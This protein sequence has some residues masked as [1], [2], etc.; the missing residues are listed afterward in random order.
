[1]KL[2]ALTLALFTAASQLSIGSTQ[3]IFDLIANF[4][5]LKNNLFACN[6]GGSSHI[7]WVLEILE[8]L[9]VRGHYVSFYTREDQA[10]FIK[11][12]PSVELV[13]N[14]PALFQPEEARV[15]LERL[16]SKEVTLSFLLSII[17][18]NDT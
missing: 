2:F 4:R 8:E 16:I 14:G 10:K 13:L 3:G 1:M 17:T 11:N 18:K 12:Y 7:V 6:V 5:E 9:A 15:L